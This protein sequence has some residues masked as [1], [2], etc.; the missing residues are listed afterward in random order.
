MR[1]FLFV[2][3]K[4]LWIPDVLKRVI[5]SSM[6]QSGSDL[7]LTDA[8][9]YEETLVYA[10]ATERAYLDP[11]ALFTQRRLYAN[12][13]NDFVVPLGTAGILNVTEVAALRAEHARESGIVSHI[14]SDPFAFDHGSKAVGGSPLD[15]MRSGLNSV[16][17]GKKIVHFPGMFPSA[18]NK[19]CAL[20]RPLYWPIN[21]W[22]A[23]GKFVMDDAVQWLCP[24]EN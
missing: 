3:D 12:L 6:R 2:D 19:I 4:G 17:W 7:F 8:S 16:G 21:H 11:L 9:S 14:T 20:N 18:H 23:E 1:D 13:E 24:C 5:A 22:F 15:A 10:M